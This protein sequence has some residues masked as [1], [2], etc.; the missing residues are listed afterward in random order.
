[1]DSERFSDPLPR[2]LYAI[3]F[4]LMQDT[5]LPAMSNRATRARAALN[6][7]QITVDFL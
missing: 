5:A 1:M 3:D 2:N 6:E 4:F 7:F